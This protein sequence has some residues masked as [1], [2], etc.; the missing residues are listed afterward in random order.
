R[1]QGS[2][3]G[4]LAVHH[5]PG[6]GAPGMRLI[7]VGEA[8]GTAG[9]PDCPLFPYP[10]GSAGARL[11]RLT[12]LTRGDYLRT[13]DR[14]NLVAEYPGETYPLDRARATVDMLMVSLLRGRRLVGLGRKV[15]A[16]FR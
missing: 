2:V 12:G 5:R 10:Q 7:L 6:D 8:P 1:H 13:F 15:A 3:P 9:R 14:M 4:A 11:Q 16:A